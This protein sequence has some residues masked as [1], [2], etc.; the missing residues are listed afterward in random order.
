MVT[1]LKRVVVLKFRHKKAY[2]LWEKGYTVVE[3]AFKGAR[4]KKNSMLCF[5]CVQ[6]AALRE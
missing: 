2:W 6:D 1:F 5:T 3:P 4:R